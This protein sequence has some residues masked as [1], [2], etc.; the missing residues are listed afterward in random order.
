M[1]VWTIILPTTSVLQLEVQL[2][3]EHIATDC[4]EY[5]SEIDTGGAAIAIASAWY[6]VQYVLNPETLPNVFLNSLVIYFIFH[7]LHITVIDG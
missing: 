2:Q 7:Y 6:L 1:R 3:V 4:Y 5:A